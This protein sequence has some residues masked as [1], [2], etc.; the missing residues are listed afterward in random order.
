MSNDTAKTAT[1]SKT[2]Q[3]IK[4]LSRAKGAKMDE[5]TCA[6]NWQPHS[7]RA[8]L[9]GL[10]KKGHT[11]V[12]EARSDGATAYRITKAASSASPLQIPIAPSADVVESKAVVEV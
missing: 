8:Y 2:E 12:R 5:L 10:R 11:I 7:C 4:L 6:T 1:P 9:T 3:V